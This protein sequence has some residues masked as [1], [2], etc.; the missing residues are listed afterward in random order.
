MVLGYNVVLKVL[1]HIMAISK[2]STAQFLVSSHNNKIKL[3]SVFHD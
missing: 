2:S 1:R 3:F